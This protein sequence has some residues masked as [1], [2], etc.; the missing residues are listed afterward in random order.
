MDRIKKRN[1]HTHVSLGLPLTFILSEEGK[2]RDG[3]GR[4]GKGREGKGWEGKGRDGK[5]REG[6]G[7]KGGEGSEWNG[8]EELTRR[9]PFLNKGFANEPMDPQGHGKR[10]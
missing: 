8:R 4:D 1:I 6:R 9:L 7:E 10:R 2:G 5:G 3:K